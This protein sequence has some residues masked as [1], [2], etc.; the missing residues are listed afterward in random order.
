MVMRRTNRADLRESFLSLTPAGRQIY[1]DLTPIAL[2]F[3]KRLEDAIAP[4]DR[5][6]FERAMQSLTERSATLTSEFAKVV[7]GG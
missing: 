7:R 5:P 6:A 1:D 4:G 3:A 2:N